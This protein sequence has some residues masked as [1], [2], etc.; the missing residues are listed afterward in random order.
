MVKAGSERGREG[1]ERL[2]G[3]GDEAAEGRRLDG[4][5]VCVCFAMLGVPLGS[6]SLTGGKWIRDLLSRL[7]HYITILNGVHVCACMYVCVNLR[8]GLPFFCTRINVSTQRLYSGDRKKCVCKWDST[9]SCCGQKL[10][11]DQV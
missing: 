3:R 5:L 10:A 6:A 11:G 4:G 1:G 8:R 7:H 2:G 9:W